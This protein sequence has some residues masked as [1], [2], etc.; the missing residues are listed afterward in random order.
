MRQ[1]TGQHLVHDHARCVH[2]HAC[3]DALA[4]QL[5]GC[6]VVGRAHQRALL[7]Q[8]RGE[9]LTLD[10]RDAEVDELELY[11]APLVEREHQVFGLDV[12]VNDAALGDRHQRQ[13]EL[14][15]ERARFIHAEL[16]A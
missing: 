11:L 12:A 8:A 5:L 2:V 10:E 9:G 16:A 14:T 4:A 13:Q 6:H 1:R 3:I 15:G 7:R